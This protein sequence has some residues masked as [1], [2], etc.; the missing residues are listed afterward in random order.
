MSYQTETP[1]QIIEQLRPLLDGVNLEVTRMV[2]SSGAVEYSGIALS[3]E[4]RCPTDPK[5]CVVVAK[6]FRFTRSIALVVSLRAQLE[7]KPRVCR[8]TACDKKRSDS[9]MVPSLLGPA[10]SAVGATDEP[11]GQLLKTDVAQIARHRALARNSFTM[12]ERYREA[13]ILRAAVEYQRLSAEHYR[14]ARVLLGIES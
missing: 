7:I 14:G 10:G 6:D 12:V 9:A 5:L 13:G 4:G 11:A 8:C 1:E 2:S 3:F